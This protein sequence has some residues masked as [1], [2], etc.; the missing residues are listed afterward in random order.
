[1][2]FHAGKRN[3]VRSTGVHLRRHAILAP[4]RRLIGATTA[5][6]LAGTL[7]IALPAATAAA[8]EPWSG[9][10]T[11]TISR[12]QVDI[13]NTSAVVTATT[14]AAVPY[15]YYLSIYDDQGQRLTSCNATFNICGTSNTGSLST[16]INVSNN[17]TRTFTAY[18]SQ[19]APPR[20]TWSLSPFSDEPSIS[21]INDEACTPS[22][23]ERDGQHRVATRPG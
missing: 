3:L 5:A 23:Y 12:T 18:V 4:L 1:M 10:A 13:H 20:P 16:T 17:A 9:T 19:D 7:L 22:P 8:V 2:W 21:V 6:A 14:S 15:P 11:L